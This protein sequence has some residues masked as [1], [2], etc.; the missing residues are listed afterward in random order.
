MSDDEQEEIDFS[1][2]VEWP[3]SDTEQQE[4][5]LVEVSE[6]NKRKNAL[7]ECRTV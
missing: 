7:G 4:S 6:K 1:K 5:K 2:A 3:D